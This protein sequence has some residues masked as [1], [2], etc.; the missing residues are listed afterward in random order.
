MNSPQSLRL[1]L[2]WR[3]RAADYLSLERNVTLASAVVLLLGFGDEQYAS[4]KQA[5]RN[6]VVL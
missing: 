6:V 2:S 3:A 1:M 5:G 4:W